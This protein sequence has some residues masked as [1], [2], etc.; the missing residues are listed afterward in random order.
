MQF[1]K[2]IIRVLVAS[3]VSLSVPV[4]AQQQVEEL[5]FPNKI[6]E[7]KELLEHRWF[8]VE[9]IVFERL[10]VLDL[11][12]DETLT[13]SKPRQYPENLQMLSTN[14]AV[15]MSVDQPLK[16]R[17]LNL[18]QQI[19]ANAVTWDSPLQP[20]LT[21]IAEQL[22]NPQP[23]WC[24][25]YPEILADA[26]HPS[27]YPLSPFLQALNEESDRIELEVQAE[28]L[29]ELE[30]VDAD[31]VLPNPYPDPHLDMQANKDA[32]NGQTQKSFSPEMASFMQ[33]YAAWLGNIESFE[34]SL[35]AQHLQVL[36]QNRLQETV[37]FINRRQTLRPL[38][39]LAWRQAV[40]DRDNPE[41]V[42]I[43][44]Q[45]SPLNPDT[46]NAIAK[47]D[48]TISVT[49]SR[50]LHLATNLTY[51]ADGLGR[52]PINLS[53]TAEPIDSAQPTDLSYM[54]MQQSRRL[55]SEELHYLDHPK[56]GL[57]VRVD[58]VVT[59]EDLESERL[60]L[61]QLHKQAG[62]N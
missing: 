34:Q 35:V 7:V 55:R 31:F 58:P 17:P 26:I 9:I 49:V 5:R 29:S 24:I 61:Q 27:Y 18:Q 6:A 12:E 28:L 14:A 43:Q 36:K 39:H 23:T 30:N 4:L 15:T 53:M 13:L 56:F 22:N 1:R 20:N 44:S 45:N 3:S 54:L 37:K 52:E 38:V 50:Y 42:Y 10:N 19:D 2:S 41:P 21:S 11:T 59:P 62:Q 48:G 51:N 25:G 60:A 32:E 47:L 8:D 46:L 16:L 57:I 40:P 33:R